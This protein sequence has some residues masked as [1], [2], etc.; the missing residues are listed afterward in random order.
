MQSTYA[1]VGHDK[2]P[3]V[4]YDKSD[5]RP[6]SDDYLEIFTFVPKANR[7]GFRVAASA[8]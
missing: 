8:R 5:R 6:I 1:L 4:A 7:G 2:Y 3:F